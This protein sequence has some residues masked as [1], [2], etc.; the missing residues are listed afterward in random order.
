M[1]FS[2]ATKYTGSGLNYTI[3]CGNSSMKKIM[4]FHTIIMAR[5]KIF[6]F[7]HCYQPPTT[8]SQQTMVQSW[9]SYPGLWKFKA[10][11][12][13]VLKNRCLTTW[14]S[15]MLISTISP[16]IT[17]DIESYSV[18]IT[19]FWPRCLKDPLTQLPLHNHKLFVNRK[20]FHL[21]LA[22]ALYCNSNQVSITHIHYDLLH[23][24]VFPPF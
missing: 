8:S 20:K 2:Y 21:N 17:I 5:N 19:S 22:I 9:S 6:L 13:N 15:L 4:W 23:W 3:N 16:F 24:E 14:F 12:D 1:Y 11:P 7:L 18:F 10:M